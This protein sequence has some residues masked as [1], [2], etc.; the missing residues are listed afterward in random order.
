MI[1]P[2]ERK[3]IVVIG[4]GMVGHRFCER[5]IEYD[6]AGEYR[7]VTFCEEPRA[8]YDRV[9]LTTFFAHRDA[10]K[11]MIARKEWY[12]EHGIELHIGDRACEVN[13]AKKL[14]RSDKGVEIAYDAIVMATGSFPFVPPVPGI[15]NAGVFVYRTIEDLQHMIEYAKHSKRCAVIG[16]GLLGL[17]AAKAAYDLGLETHVIEFAPRLMP[18]QIDDRGSK[19]LV[20]KIEALGVKV[21][22]NIGTKEVLGKSHVEGLKFS[23]DTELQVDML[24]VSAGIRP[25]DDLAKSCGLELGARG[26]IAVNDHLRTSDPDIYAVG[27]CA[28]HSGMIYGLVAPGYDM[29]DIVAWNFCASGPGSSGPLAPCL[30]GERARV[31]GPNGENASSNA[32]DSASSPTC[33]SKPG[34]TED[35]LTLTLSPEDGGEGTGKGTRAAPRLFTGA[36]MST[37]LKLM[38]VDVASFG[39]YEADEKTAKSLVF[40]DPFDGVYKKILVSLDGTKLLGGMLVGNADDYGRLLMTCKSDKPLSVTPSELLLGPKGHAAGGGVADLDDNAQIC[41]CNNVSKGR[42]CAAIASGLCTVADLKSKTKAGAG[43]GGCVP[44]VTDLLNSELK[45]AGKTINTSL[46]EHFAFTRQ[47]LFDIVKVKGY[48]TFAELVAGHGKGHGC[49]IC[50]PAVASILASLWNENVMDHTVLQDSNDR[51]LANIQRGGTFSVVPRIAGGEV[52]PEKLIVL[53]QVG[54]KYNLY[55]KITGGQRIDLFGAAV[56]Q[57]PDIWEE[58]IAGGFESGHA[59]GKALRTVKSCVGSTWCRYGVQDSV[60]FAVRIENRYKGLRSPH[61]VKSA[62]S[63]CVREC[64]EAQCK[65]FGLIATEHGYNLYVCGNGGAKPRH[66]DLLASDI[67]EETAIT[68]ID[69]FLMYYVQ[70][71]DRL[72]RTSVWLDKMEGG[73]EALRGVIVDDKL[74]ICADL[75][76]QMQFCV[77]SY[78][79]EWTEVVNDPERRRLFKQFV[80]TDETE[81]TIEVVSARGQPH[82]APWTDGTVSLGQLT[83]PDGRTLAEAATEP[84]SQLP[85]SLSWQPV[86]KVWDFPVEGGA[87]IKHG[88]AQIAVFNF[89]SRGEWYASDNMCPHKQEFVLSRGIIGDTNGTPKVACPVHKKTFS[90]QDGR[91]LNDPDYSIRTYPVKVD[92]DDV[93]LLLP[94]AEQLATV[95]AIEQRKCGGSCFA[96]APV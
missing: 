19:V 67:D 17:E 23:D 29:A 43:C 35:P 96:C 32:N 89:A 14:V 49:E 50:K 61:K 26:G 52:T 11:L 42:L 74:G 36:D 69:R 62:V 72:T 80:N 92:G 24:V 59:Y 45:K 60:G 15:K 87:T 10:E 64:A 28:L 21:H 47:E 83:L 77:D 65:D 90:L 70:T 85:P 55:T 33:S 44:L 84:E 66:A 5:L 6:V 75:E 37:K 39:N 12:L 22:L 95:P 86:G 8:A 88:H 71:A 16:G 58:L 38:G 41:S 56:H 25:R 3:T 54:R 34:D 9:G 81:P 78:K 79:C 91:G 46:C 40:E 4:N 57:L 30:E 48:R 2:R 7:L 18:R 31:R 76:R 1:A 68:Y 27:E 51:F 20:S 82:P 53:G 13:R 93:L 63:G 94:P 73:I